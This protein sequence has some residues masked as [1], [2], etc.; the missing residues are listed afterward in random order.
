M[1]EGTWE[2][3]KVKD[4]DIYNDESI[5][6]NIQKIIPGLLAVKLV[7]LNGLL[8]HTGQFAHVGLSEKDYDGIPVIYID[9]LFFDS[10]N[11]SII[12]HEIDEIILWEDL[13]VNIIHKERNEMREWI[14]TNIDEAKTHAK[15]IHELSYDLAEFMSFFD[16]DD[17]HVYFNYDYIIDMFERYLQYES[18]DINISSNA[19]TGES[20]DEEIFDY[21]RSLSNEIRT[22]VDILV[23]G[24][25][26]MQF[27]EILAEK[28]ND[29]NVKLMLKGYYVDV[30]SFP[31]SQSE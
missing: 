7:S 10:P 24:I 17:E 23:S 12:K 6:G 2:E 9:S 15:R 27:D 5:N 19:P 28:Q 31:D 4:L 26:E 16:L 3:L 1:G 22:A 18:I 8:S 30:Y 25:G 20:S 29:V 13:R 21:F 11:R 14:K